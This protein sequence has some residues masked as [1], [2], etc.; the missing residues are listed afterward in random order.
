[1]TQKQTIS[2]KEQKVYIATSGSDYLDIDAYA[3]C[4]AMKELLCLQGI[5]A[6]AYSTAQTNYSICDFLIHPGQ[7]STA[8]PD[9]LKLDTTKYIIVDVSNPNYFQKDIPQ[10]NIIAVYDHHIGFEDYWGKLIG[11]K[12]CIEFIGAAATLVFREWKKSGMQKQMTRDTALLLV[13][14]ILD[15]TLNLM[16]GNTTVED[17]ESLE[18]LCSIAGIND[19]W[20]SYYFLEVQKKIEKDL[21]NALFRD[22]KKVASD[23]ELPEYIGQ[24]AVWN[25][26]A[27]LEKIDV[28]R[29]WFNSK[30]KDWMLN[31]V[32][33]E[34]HRACFVCD[35]SFFEDKISHIFDISFTN[36]IAELEQPY[37]RKQIIKKVK[38]SKNND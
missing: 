20:R 16:S 10:D 35:D 25:S 32:D 36:G 13:A 7:I 26:G 4:V 21:K 17:I 18:E 22:V 1:M 2:N 28:I 9:N 8:L 33:I 19:E 23:I 3:C 14:A 38:E 5:N 34:H 31:I 29:E 30:W 6:I 15:N 27:V 37:L 11:E 24:V 12:A